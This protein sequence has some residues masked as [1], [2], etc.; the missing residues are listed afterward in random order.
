VGA[1]RGKGV[2]YQRRLPQQ[3]ESAGLLEPA[4]QRAPPGRAPEMRERFVE[5]PI[6]LVALLFLAP[7]MLVI[8]AIVRLHDGGPALFGHVRVGKDGRRFRCLKFR[9]MA[10]DAEDR[11]AALLRSD[12]QAREEWRRDHK[13][14]NDPRVTNIGRFLRKSSLDELPQLFNVLLGEM[15]LVGPR[16]IV[17]AEITRY[18]R[19][20][21]RYCSI[22][23]GVTGLWQVSGRNEVDYRRRVALDLLYIKRRNLP[24]YLWILL[25]TVPAVLTRRGAH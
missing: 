9:S 10:P 6:C 1:S 5:I 4:M 11:L 23:P 25:A 19:F 17:A 20:Y 7:L 13:L 21:A 2:G 22:R 16:P 8:A 15:S 18:G 3:C 12:P 14:R 24:F